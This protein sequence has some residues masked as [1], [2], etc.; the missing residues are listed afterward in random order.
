MCQSEQRR[1]EGMECYEKEGKGRKQM[2]R[3]RKRE[4]VRV[5]PAGPRAVQ[6]HTSFTQGQKSF[7]ENDRKKTLHPSLSYSRGVRVRVREIERERE[8]VCDRI[9]NES[10]ETRKS[11]PSNSFNSADLVF[12]SFALSQT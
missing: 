8:C 6:R 2:E 10:E 9:E 4:S 1:E 3:E 11:S 7:R 12:V 5:A